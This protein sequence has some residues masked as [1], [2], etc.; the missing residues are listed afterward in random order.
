MT[1][2]FGKVVDIF[3]VEWLA[4]VTREKTY[5]CLGDSAA[6]VIGGGL[7]CVSRTCGP[8]FTAFD[9]VIIA[10]SIS[11]CAA[12]RSSCSH[13]VQPIH[14]ERS[15]DVAVAEH[16]L[17]RLYVRPLPHKEARQAVSEVMEPEAHL[18]A[19]FKHTRLHGGR[20]EVIFNQHVRDPGQL[21]LE[22]V[23]G[24]HPVAGELLFRP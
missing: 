21:T 8:Q 1:G 4:F 11:S 10:V 23:A 18:L 19:F 13:A 16:R 14:P 20:T 6:E 7:T 9:G 17:H 22:P 15:S 3:E 2:P 5:R 24:K 12:R